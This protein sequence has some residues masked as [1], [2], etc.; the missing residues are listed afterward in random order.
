MLKIP[1]ISCFA[2]GVEALIAAKALLKHGK[3]SSDLVLIADEMYLVREAQY[4]G[5]S[6]ISVNE[7]VDHYRRGAAFMTNGLKEIVPM[8]IR[9]SLE[10]IINGQW[11]SQKNVICICRLS[12]AGFKVRGIV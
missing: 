10:I 8:V 9:L 1:C 4:S 12:E 7:E 5:G 2:G 11:L 6:Y 3:I